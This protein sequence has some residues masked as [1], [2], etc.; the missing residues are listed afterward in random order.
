[1]YDRTYSTYSSHSIKD[2]S[3]ERVDDTLVGRE[4]EKSKILEVAFHAQNKSRQPPVS[5]RWEAEDSDT[6]SEKQ[7]IRGTRRKYLLPSGD[8]LETQEK[9]LGDPAHPV[10]APS[11][12]GLQQVRTSPP[13]PDDEEGEVTPGDADIPGSIARALLDALQEKRMGYQLPAAMGPLA[14][15]R[16]SQLQQQCLAKGSE[17][18]EAVIQA[19]LD[20]IAVGQGPADPLALANKVSMVSQTPDVQLNAAVP[21]QDSSNSFNTTARAEAAEGSLYATIADNIHICIFIKLHITAQSGPVIRAILCH[22]H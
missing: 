18:T 7:L 2:A 19:T 14:R 21:A 10:E 1:M 17:P 8:P 22:S 6:D 20:L 13:S 9:T 11:P 12:P 3:H 5:H 15:I 4:E 16:A